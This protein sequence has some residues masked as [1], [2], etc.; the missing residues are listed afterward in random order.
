MALSNDALSRASALLSLAPQSSRSSHPLIIHQANS[1]PAEARFLLVGL[2]MAALATTYGRSDGVVKVRGSLLFV[3]QQIMLC[4]S[5]LDSIT[6]KGTHL[7]DVFPAISI[8]G[9]NERSETRAIYL[10][11]PGRSQAIHRKTH[12]GAVVI[13]ATHPRSIV[14]LETLLEI[15]SINS[16]PVIIV[17]APMAGLL[18]DSD[19]GVTHWVWEYDSAIQIEK[20]LKSYDSETAQD[21]EDG[22]DRHYWV[23]KNTNVEVELEEL[24]KLLAKATQLSHRAASSSLLQAWSIYH[25]L[26]QLCVPL[27]YVERSWRL[28]PRQLMLRDQIEQLDGLDETKSKDAAAYL[29]INAPRI[30]ELITNL[31]TTYAHCGEPDKFYAIGEAIESLIPNCKRPIRVVTQTKQEAFILEE[32]L[33]QLV[34][35]I[36]IAINEGKLEFVHQREEAR[37]IADG[38]YRL[39]ILSGSRTSRFR[40]LDFYP[41]WPTHVVT[42]SYE[43]AAERHVLDRSYRQ[44]AT[45]TNESY[46]A[47]LLKR[48]NLS[49]ENEPVGS[50]E[51]PNVKKLNY[52]IHGTVNDHWQTIEAL[53]DASFEVDWVDI[54]PSDVAESFW[55]PPGSNSE[56]EIH[57]VDD[58]NESHY[59]FSMQFVD[60]YYPET[61][62]IRRINADRLRVEDYLIIV[63]DDRYD[64]LFSRVRQSIDQERPLKETLLLDR[65]RVAK[66]KLLAQYDGDRAALF[67]DVGASLRVEYQAL[68]SWFREDDDTSENEEQIIGP[69]DYDDFTVIAMKSGV[70]RDEGDMAKTFAA[71][72]SERIN[73]RRLGRSLHKALKSLAQGSSYDDARKAAESLNTP[74]EDVLN[75]VELRQIVRLESTLNGDEEA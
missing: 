48:L 38:D 20:V 32:L 6:L 12:F 27:E 30:K 28:T 53:E 44:L 57:V 33:P 3:S 35:G 5:L 4:R 64:T 67:E 9:K 11:N 75:A 37:R 50:D 73:R 31:Y 40:Y 68:L 70:Y 42:F 56:P 10:A 43:A 36:D 29:A 2:S 21:F 26:R 65:W 54:T 23:P 45:F 19:S 60:V 47:S 63:V 72:K 51:K 69:R 1:S 18:D 46:R 66:H 49:Q 59:F 39:T 13:D 34:D 17:L 15:P 8:G 41:A 7:T 71:I 58:E 16:S 24:Y 62:Q 74:V 55:R 52:H 61:E 22:L 25:R 14:H